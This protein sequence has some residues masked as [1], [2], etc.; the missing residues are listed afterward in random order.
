MRIQNRVL[1]SATFTSSCAWTADGLKTG[2]HAIFSLK[3]HVRRSWSRWNVQE[4]FDFFTVKSYCQDLI[5]NKKRQKIQNKNIDTKETAQNRK[6]LE[7]ELTLWSRSGGSGPSG[8]RWRSWWDDIRVFIAV[9][10]NSDALLTSRAL[11][12]RRTLAIAS[13]H[14]TVDII[15]LKFVKIF[16]FGPI[17][18]Q[19]TCQHC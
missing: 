9:F 5:K 7:Y 13:S 19:F 10:D 14:R 17:K 6:T 3:S 15:F 11:C 1:Q 12:F 4:R 16:P 8:W 2:W 18:F